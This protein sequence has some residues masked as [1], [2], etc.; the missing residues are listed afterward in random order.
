MA[1][2]VYILCALTSLACAVMLIRAYVRSRQRF[3]LWAS[4]CFVTLV[5]NN[6]LLYVDSVIVPHVDLSIPRG[7]AALLGITA[8]VFGL[9]WEEQ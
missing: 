7:A 1:I 3:L 4:F 6:M 5:L 8:L 9:V 2:P